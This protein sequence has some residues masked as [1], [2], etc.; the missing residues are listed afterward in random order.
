MFAALCFWLIRD[1]ATGSVLTS[2]S[3]ELSN[4]YTNSTATLTFGPSFHGTFTYEPTSNV[5][6]SLSRKLRNLNAYPDKFV[7]TFV[8][9][10][11][12]TVLATD[13]T[14]FGNRNEIVQN[15]STALLNIDETVTLTQAQLVNKFVPFGW[16]TPMHVI[17]EG[18]QNI[19][20]VALSELR[21]GSTRDVIVEK[22]K[23]ILKMSALNENQLYADS[24]INSDNSVGTNNFI[25]F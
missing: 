12:L 19:F 1:P 11:E 25:M 2:P 4:L 5:P 20:D 3:G 16:P 15:L 24:G 6:R 21:K 14:V 13:N 10:G 18:I 9:F 22:I 8:K 7:T 23:E 17:Q